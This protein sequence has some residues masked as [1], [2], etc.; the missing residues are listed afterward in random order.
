MEKSVY[1]IIRRPI[2]TEKGVIKKDEERTLCF[3]VAPIANK[4]Q[5]KQAVESLFKVKVEEVRTV[6][7]VGKLRRRGKFAGYRS[8]WK[9]AYVRLL[10]GQK[11]PEYTEI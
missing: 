10:P 4:T 3:E 6:N 1:D 2:V 5:I 7:N 8:D 9:K 11:A